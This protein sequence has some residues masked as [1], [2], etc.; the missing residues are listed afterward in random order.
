MTT[1]Q[2]L[3]T[4]G[5]LQNPEIQRIVM[6]RE[7]TGKKDTLI[8]YRLEHEKVL[9]RYPAVIHTGNPKDKVRGMVYKT[10]FR[11]LFLC[12][13]YEGTHYKRIRETLNSGLESWVYI[14]NLD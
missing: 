6:D 8:G 5:T 4:Y 3:F 7:L 2:H 11:D 14:E 12:D 1:T 10:S 9:G 13:E